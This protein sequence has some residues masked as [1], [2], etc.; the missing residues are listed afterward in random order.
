ENF[1]MPRVFDF[2][3]PG[4]EIREVDQSQVTRPQQEDGLLVVGMARSGPG[5]QP[6]STMVLSCI[7]KNLRN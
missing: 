4:V 5:N 1:L 2:V 7:E 3:S 6:L